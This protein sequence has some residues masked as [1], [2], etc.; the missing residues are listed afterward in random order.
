M[1]LIRASVSTSKKKTKR[2]WASSE[3]KRQHEQLERDWQTLKQKW[4]VTNVSRRKQKTTTVVL[5]TQ[6]SVVVRDT[7]PKPKSLNSWQTGAVNSKPTIQYTGDN[8]LGITIVHKS[9]LQPVFNKEA[10]IDAAKMRR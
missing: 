10:A 8:V 4:G 7:G 9:C 6:M 3:Q 1:H 5:P 2:K